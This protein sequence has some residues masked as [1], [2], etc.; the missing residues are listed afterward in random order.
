MALILTLNRKLHRAHQRVREGNFSL[1]GL[2]GVDL[3]GR[4]ASVIGMGK[5]GRC[6]A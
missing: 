5:I 1:A 2:E 4:T 3:Y 6:L